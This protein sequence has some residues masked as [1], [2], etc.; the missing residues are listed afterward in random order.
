MDDE[1]ASS[2]VEQVWIVRQFDSILSSIFPSKS[3]MPCC[4]GIAG[5]GKAHP[6]INLAWKFDCAPR[7]LREAT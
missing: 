2:S 6:R 3:T 1:A 5:S 4:T 7:V